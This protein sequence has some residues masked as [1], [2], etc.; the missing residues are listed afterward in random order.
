MNYCRENFELYLANAEFFGYN[1]SMK[2]GIFGG[3]FDPVHQEHV[4][5]AKSAMR[6]LGLD[7]LIVMP[8]YRPPH[9][10]GKSITSAEHRLAM[11]R[12]A[13]QIPGVRVSDYE[14]EREGMSYTYLTCRAFRM[15]YP[16]DELFFLVGTD[17]LEDFYTWRNP[18]DI[19]R[20]VT[21]AVCRR[22]RD[23]AYLEEQ[24]RRF[25]ARFGMSFAVVDYN[26]A[27]VS[28][29][30]V[31][32]VARLGGDFKSDVPAAV[33]EYIRK[34]NLY[35]DETLCRALELENP[36]RREHSVRVAVMAVEHAKTF[37]VD[38]ES[39]C[40]AAALHDVA[41]N[42]KP[43]NRLLKGFV[44][45]PDVPPSVVHQ[46][47]GAYVA[48]HA[49]GVTDPNVL[50]AIRYHTSGREGMSALEKLIFLSDLLESG[51]EFPGVDELRALMETDQTA[52]LVLALKRQVEYVRER[53]LE[54]YPLTEQAYAYYQ[55]G[56][57]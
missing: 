38:E 27:P 49:F 3:S 46:F 19:L 53:G 17:M 14:I 6:S 8:A 34:H 29:T 48:E 7:E 42:L 28:S 43:D 45:P 16:A 55:G 30:E 15:R 36:S 18:E 33:A 24:Q 56:R 51:R 10:R 44:C 54:V 32:T 4:N 39:A 52:C 20:N 22:D 12:L 35:R 31:R 37:G 26:G 50:N 57:T 25:E 13:F 41:K 47:A 11:C 23:E 40:L 21:L 5:V 2:I 9:K 1:R